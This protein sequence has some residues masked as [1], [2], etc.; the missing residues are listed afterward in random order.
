[1][2]SIKISNTAIVIAE[3]N[4]YLQSNN[5]FENQETKAT[6]ERITNEWTAKFEDAIIKDLKSGF[7][8]IEVDI[9]SC[10]FELVSEGT[11]GGGCVFFHRIAITDLIKKDLIKIILKSLIAF[12]K[13]QAYL[14]SEYAN[15]LKWN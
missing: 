7:N 11:Q 13:T 1:M 15:T 8:G 3:L 6:D 9:T 4:N 14:A 10:E 12:S 2:F 5:Y